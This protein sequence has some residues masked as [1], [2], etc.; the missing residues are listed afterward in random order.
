MKTVFI[1]ALCEPG[2]G[3]VRY[4]GKAKNL[5]NR[6]AGHLCEARRSKRNNRRLS[7]IRARLSSGLTPELET[8][9][10]VLESEW[11][12]AEAAYIEFYRDSGCNLV[13]ST[14]GGEG[15][16]LPPEKHPM[17]GKRHSE[18]SKLKMRQ[19]QLG[20]HA[21]EKNRM[22]GK[23][24]TD[25]AKDK[26]RQAHIGSWDG[27]K[28]PMFGSARFGNKN[29]F[30]GKTHTPEAMLKKRITFVFNRLLAICQP[31]L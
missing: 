1:Y 23:T 13:N 7:W 12:A 25:A 31:I 29:P 24:H 8:I 5:T 15:V 21:G 6:L 26:I 9:D 18:K 19:T 22:F 27:S 2:S 16:N 20:R 30:Y 10:E 4:V 14:P 17:L 3:A 11:Q 28:N